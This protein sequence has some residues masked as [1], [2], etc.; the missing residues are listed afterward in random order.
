M[1]ISI[2]IPTHNESAC[3]GKLI[4]DVFKE[5][6]AIKHHSFTVLVIDGQ[7]TDGTREII[8]QRKTLYPSLYLLT[9]K[10]KNG[11]GGAYVAGINY[12]ITKLNADAFMEFDG[13]GQHDPHDIPALVKKMDEGWACVIGSRY[14]SGGTIPKEW[15]RYRKLLSKFG[16]IVI[17][18][19][20]GLKIKD[21]TSG[22]KLT[23]IARHKNT[24]PL[25]VG[26]L[27]SLRHA[28][29]IQFLY[30]L[31][32]SGISIA[33]VPIH[34]LNRDKGVSKSTFMDIAESLKVI[35][36]LRLFKNA[37][38]KNAKTAAL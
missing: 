1:N 26:T 31:T 22:F 29:K 15:R 34:F 32:R 28:Y 13:D 20:L 5:I 33:E 9:E 10:K 35:L 8:S 37:G 18:M 12:A 21:T 38:I 11:L 3:I 17:R 30:T 7:S 16:N 6:S 24:L 19:A 25:N 14:V 36:Y 27:I 2:L 23:K 4:D